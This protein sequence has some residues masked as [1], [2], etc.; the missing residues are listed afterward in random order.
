MVYLYNGFACSLP[1]VKIQQRN[2]KHMFMVAGAVLWKC[3]E[4]YW[5]LGSLF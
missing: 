4:Y 5:D 1:P 3:A 2:K